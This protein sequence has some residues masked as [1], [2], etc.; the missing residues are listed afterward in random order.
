MNG[1]V[2]LVLLAVIGV[3]LGAWWFLYG[4]AP[5]GPKDR[6]GKVASG[7]PAR[8]LMNFPGEAES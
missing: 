7:A 3:G 8:S 2:I 5:N 4:G 6:G 1:I